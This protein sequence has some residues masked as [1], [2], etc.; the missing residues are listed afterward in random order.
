MHGNT[1]TKQ[2]T[3]QQT[4]ST[5]WIY[6]THTEQDKTIRHRWNKRGRDRTIGPGREGTKGGSVEQEEGNKSLKWCWKQQAFKK[7]K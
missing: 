4:W 7:D 2:T 1:H 3:V 5:A 6:C